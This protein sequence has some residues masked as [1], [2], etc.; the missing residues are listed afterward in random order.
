MNLMG[1]NTERWRWPTV[2]RIHRPYLHL[3]IV[4][5]LEL[6]PERRGLQPQK[7]LE[8]FLFLI[9]GVWWNLIK[10]SMILRSLRAI[11]E[12]KGVALLLNHSIIHLLRRLMKWIK[13]LIRRLLQ[14]PTFINLNFL[15]ITDRRFLHNLQS[16]ISMSQREKKVMD[17]DLQHRRDNRIPNLI[18]R[19]E[20]KKGRVFHNP[21][22]TLAY[23][24]RQK[25]IGH[26]LHVIPIVTLELWRKWLFSPAITL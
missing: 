3:K 2:L 14:K 9:S 7:F 1:M 20:S 4:V 13:Y 8:G 15:Q 24:P 18:L 17:R 26:L 16:F 11:T 21:R 12:M 22:V 5:Y 25:I 23:S 10:N 19:S 6:T